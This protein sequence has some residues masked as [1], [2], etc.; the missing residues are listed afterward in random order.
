MLQVEASTP[1]EMAATNVYSY[2]P[3]KIYLVKCVILKLI[4]QKIF[5]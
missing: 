2:N 5:C 1:V 3:N 4:I